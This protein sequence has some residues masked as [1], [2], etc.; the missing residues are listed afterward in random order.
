MSYLCRGRSIDYIL[1]L[2]EFEVELVSILREHLCLPGMGVSAT[3]HFRD[4]LTMRQIAHEANIRVPE[5]I[6]IK[7][8]DQLRDYMSVV[9]SCKLISLGIEDKSCIPTK[10]CLGCSS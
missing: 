6:Q 2:D 5:F 4:K 1:P 10:F 9:P 7:N 3:R 8:Y